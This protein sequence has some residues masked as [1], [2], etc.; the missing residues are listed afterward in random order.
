MARTSGTGDYLPFYRGY[1]EMP[2]AASD[3]TLLPV[4]TDIEGYRNFLSVAA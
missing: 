2:V 1:Q 4:V 3:C